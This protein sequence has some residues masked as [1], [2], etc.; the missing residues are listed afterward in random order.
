MDAK[1]SSE[2]IRSI[3]TGGMVEIVPIR[4]VFV[5]ILQMLRGPTGTDRRPL[6]VASDDYVAGRSAVYE[7]QDLFK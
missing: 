3:F 2:T 6:L 1:Y 7:N 4:L 5:Q